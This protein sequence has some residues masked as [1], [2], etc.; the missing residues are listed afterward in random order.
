MSA[1]KQLYEEYCAGRKTK[2]KQKENSTYGDMP[3]QCPLLFSLLAYSPPA[4]AGKVGFTITVF[5]DD[6]GLKAVLTDKANKKS[7]FL[8]LSDPGDVFGD[9]EAELAA[10]RVV[11]RDRP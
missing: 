4:A 10:D 6:E 8:C 11:W 2:R 9:I 3:K 5:L 7:A 1:S